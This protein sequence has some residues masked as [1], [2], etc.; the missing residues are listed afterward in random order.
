MLS[1]MMSWEAH[2]LKD[3]PCKLHLLPIFAGLDLGRFRHPSHVAVIVPEGLKGKGRRRYVQV[4][5]L[6]LDQEPYLT[7]I[8]AI[9]ELLR[10]FPGRI[11]T[12]YY[13]NTRGELEA[14]REQGLLPYGWR[15]VKLTAENKP[16]MA[17]RL[18]LALEQGRLKLLPDGRQKRSL[19][20]VNALLQAEESAGEHGEALTSLMLALEAAKPRWSM[21][22]EFIE[23]QI[24]TIYL[25]HAR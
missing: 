24:T 25:G 20:Q 6:W 12:V 2:P 15:G 8:Q 11:C 13:D 22:D 16:V 3:N 10:S 18:L 5:S 23:P 21:L 4:A 17:G 19:L 1:K 7:Q 14:L 9:E